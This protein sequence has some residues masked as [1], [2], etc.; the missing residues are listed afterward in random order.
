MI[1]L[2]VLLVYTTISLITFFIVHTD[3]YYKNKNHIKVW[4]D[5]ILFLPVCII[6]IIIEKILEYKNKIVDKT[7]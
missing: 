3:F 6:G 7:M 2:K 1:I 5:I 4:V